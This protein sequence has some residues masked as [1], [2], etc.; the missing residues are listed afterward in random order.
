M[1]KTLDPAYIALLNHEHKS[2]LEFSRTL[3]WLSISGYKPD[4]ELA[5]D[6]E[7]FQNIVKTG[8]AHY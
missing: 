1:L 7:V 8:M 3:T 5:Q 6:Q 4:S 2:D